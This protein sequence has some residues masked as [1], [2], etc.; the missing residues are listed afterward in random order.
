MDVT[1]EVAARENPGFTHVKAAVETAIAAFFSGRQL[2]RALRLAELGHCI[3]QVEGVENYH[4][5]T[6]AADLP[7]ENGVLPVLGT[8]TVTELEA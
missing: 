1:V 5:L 3:Y 4:L 8:L 7:A 6:P 2:G